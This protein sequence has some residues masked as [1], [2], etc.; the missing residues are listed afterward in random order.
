MIQVLTGRAFGL[1]G[2]AFIELEGLVGRERGGRR[3][4]M[5]RTPGL[6]GGGLSVHGMGG[7]YLVFHICV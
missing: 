4:E 3:R 1:V 6:D 2:V 7:D 5:E